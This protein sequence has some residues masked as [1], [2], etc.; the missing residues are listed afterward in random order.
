MALLLVMGAGVLAQVAYTSLPYF[1]S[2]LRSGRDPNDPLSP[3]D[4]KQ[5]IQTRKPHG[6]NKRR[7]MDMFRLD[8]KAEFRP[9]NSYQGTR[10]NDEVVLPPEYIEALER[11]KWHNFNIPTYGSSNV[12]Q[13]FDPN[14]VTRPQ[15]PSRVAYNTPNI[16]PVGPPRTPCFDTNALSRGLRYLPKE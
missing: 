3:A 8:T 11:R 12:I 14:L 6:I 16:H 2:S 5:I 9:W 1:M 13:R 4:V 7:L 15:A 10:V